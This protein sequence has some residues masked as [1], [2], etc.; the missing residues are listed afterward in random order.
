MQTC[1][2]GVKKSAPARMKMQRRSRLFLWV[3]I[4]FDDCLA[5]QLTAINDHK[6]YK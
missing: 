4:D 6:G 1:L 5:R 2:Y 3:L